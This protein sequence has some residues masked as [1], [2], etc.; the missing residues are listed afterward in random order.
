MRIL[1][2]LRR[3]NLVRNY[4]STIELLADRG[5]EVE[6]VFS[7]LIGKGEAPPDLE[8]TGELVDRFP[9]RIS[10]RAA[11]EVDPASGWRGLAGAVRIWGDLG[12]YVHPRFADAP[13][14]RNRIAHR[15]KLTVRPTRAGGRAAR[16]AIALADR[17][18]RT[19][20]AR[21]AA[22]LAWLGRRLEEAIPPA[23]EVVALLGER[24]PDVV[25]VSPLIDAGSDQVEFV[26]AARAL[27]I[28]SAAC[29]A[30]WDN[31]SSKGLIRLD[32]DRVFVWNDVQV[33]EAV[34]MHDV[35][36]PRVVATGAPRFDPWFERRPSRTAAEFRREIGLEPASP[37][38]L[39]LCSSA[40][41]APNE[42]PYVERWIAALRADDEL[43]DLGVLV[44]PHPQNAHVWLDADVSQLGN[45]TIWPRAGEDV[46]DEHSR[47]DFYDSLAHG[48]A[49]VG[50]NTS[51]LIEAAIAGK[52]VLTVAD[53]T[54]AQTQAGTLHYR[55]LLHDHGGFLREA[56]DLAV[57]VAQL[58]DAVRDAAAESE[59]TLDFVGRFVRPHGLE[60]SSTA[61]LVDEIE[62]TAEL[63]AAP[64]PRPA[65]TRL[66]R[67]LLGAVAAWRRA[68]MS[69]PA[70]A[71][72]AAAE[73]L[74]T[75][76]RTRSP[77]MRI[78][79]ERRGAGSEPRG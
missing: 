71:P 40:F 73:A 16:V 9:T 36:R 14:L 70:S 33:R 65:A 8:R 30:S 74:E 68:R 28:P 27:G 26:K 72:D 57:H 58:R 22:V 25:L 46:A 61:I 12:R 48:I 78:E 51:A 34:E 23:P 79:A 29:I 39:Y 76:L 24:R 55:Y 41:I 35:A 53:E 18:E 54:F 52:S 37:Y 49:V 3:P 56:P 69:R 13:L 47:A 63:S 20:S 1:F 75:Q 7:R 31:L 15:A 67:L 11:P 32:P 5:H 4:E 62:K 43:R 64:L 44:R 60:R 38:V 10:Y 2:V 42:L 17:L 45:V 66:L 21:L 6:L 59:R 19:R 77:R 50:I